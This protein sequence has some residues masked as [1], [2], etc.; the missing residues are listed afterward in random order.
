[1]DEP[2]LNGNQ[3]GIEEEEAAGDNIVMSGGEADED[4]NDAGVDAADAAMNRG[5]LGGQ[6][7]QQQQPVSMPIDAQ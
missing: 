3:P 4:Q 7:G 2:Q 6:D 5:E 1:M